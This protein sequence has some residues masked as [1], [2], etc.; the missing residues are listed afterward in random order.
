MNTSNLKT[1]CFSLLAG[2]I[3]AAM[4]DVQANAQ[5]GAGALS[6]AH[7]DKWVEDV[8]FQFLPNTLQPE[9]SNAGA[10][11]GYFNNTP[12]FPLWLMIDM[13]GALPVD[14]DHFSVNSSEKD[15]DGVWILDLSCVDS[16][17]GF[18]KLSF[19]IDSKS[20]DAA[21]KVA[22]P[23]QGDIAFY[24]GKIGPYEGPGMPDFR[25]EKKTEEARRT[26]AVLDRIIP[27]LDFTVKLNA[28]L[29][30]NKAKIIVIPTNVQ[31]WTP[32]KFDADGYTVIC[33]EKQN[34]IW[35][36][37]LQIGEETLVSEAM[38]LDL[39]IDSWTGDV[40]YR[41]GLADKLRPNWRSIV[42]GRVELP[43]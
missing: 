28:E 7:I 9:E 40:N 31:A 32:R 37:R 30:G 25:N 23:T 35:Y 5:E 21:L 13:G 11:Q 3:L 34:G 36:V 42:D 8:K 29:Y 16:V 18:F 27:A 6:A 15:A 39:A 4:P 12:G 24:Q 14:K 1:V 22:T 38:Y 26:A 20:G 19:A 10:V 43:D 2:L 33:C 17:N 41:M